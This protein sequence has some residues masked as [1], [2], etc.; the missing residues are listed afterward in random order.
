MENIPHKS[1]KCDE[2][3]ADNPTSCCKGLGHG[4]G[5]S[6]NNYIEHVHQANL[7]NKH[8]H[9]TNMSIADS[10]AF[11]DHRC[12]ENVFQEAL[13]FYHTKG[14]H[15]TSSVY[16]LCSTSLQRGCAWNVSPCNSIS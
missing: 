9:K 3:N 5:T 10:K 1:Q 2:G 15:Y 4:Q 12:I 11:R 16:V 13:K 14:P 6:A 8:K 7:H